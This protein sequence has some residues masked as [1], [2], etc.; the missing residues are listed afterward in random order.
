VT[1]LAG[2]YLFG[3]VKAFLYSY[4][5]MLLGSMV[6]FLLGRF[7]GKPFVH[8]LAGGQEKAESWIGRLKGREKIILFFMFLLP[9]FPDDLLCAIAGTLRYSTWEFFVL[10]L[11]TR[12]T[13][14]LGT[15]VFMSGEIIPYSPLGISLIALLALAAVVCFVLMMKNYERI[16][17][18]I[19]NFFNKKDK[20]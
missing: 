19:E 15:L 17:E 16:S 6:T 4:V 5:G 11:V 2:N 20:K 3:A 1:I 10:Q 13:S 8:W 7:V 18:K 9:L 12:A 14:I